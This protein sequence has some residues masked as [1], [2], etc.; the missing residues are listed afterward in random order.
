MFEHTYKGGQIFIIKTSSIAAFVKQ[1]VGSV[2]RQVFNISTTH[3]HNYM[4]NITVSSFFEGFN[5]GN[6]PVNI[7][8]SAFLAQHMATTCIY[9]QN[10][11]YFGY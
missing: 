5:I 10:I 7:I 9:E 11:S 8:T 4:S 2:Q 1:Q 6:M 3:F